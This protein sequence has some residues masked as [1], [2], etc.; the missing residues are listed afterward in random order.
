[1][2]AENEASPVCAFF[3]FITGLDRGGAETQLTRLALWMKEMGWSVMVVSLL[4]KSGFS[5]KLE[6]AGVEVVSLDMNRGRAGVSHLLR[7]MLITRRYKPHVIISFMFHANILARL[8]GKAFRTPVIITSI[9]TDC[10]GE[11]RREW[12]ERLLS[13]WSD[14]VVFN[15]E[16]AA[17]NFMRKSVTDPVKVKVIPNG[18]EMGEGEFREGEEL[19]TGRTTWYR[20]G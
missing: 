4:P 6:E 18:I 13:R 1:M 5:F 16:R 15:S 9:R 3:F 7:A 12:V 19:R 2:S 10:Y 17:D 20:E 14:A 11:R 8:T